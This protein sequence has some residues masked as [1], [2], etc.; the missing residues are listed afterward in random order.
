MTIQ[1]FYQ[2]Y[3]DSSL[4][5]CAEPFIEQ[6]SKLK[7][8]LV[9]Y[10]LNETKERILVKTQHI[11]AVYVKQYWHTPDRKI[12]EKIL[13]NLFKIRFITLISLPI[14]FILLSNVSN[15]LLLSCHMVANFCLLIYI[16]TRGSCI[17]FGLSG[18]VCYCSL[19][20][21]MSFQQNVFIL[22]LFD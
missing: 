4:Y 20:I 9:H 14:L 5:G 21:V 22:V 10:L 2:N 3:C 18:V 13:S 15:D 6:H 11:V 16:F 17:R 19:R 12:K 1:T 7:W 8:S